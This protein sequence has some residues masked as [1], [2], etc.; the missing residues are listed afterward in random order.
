MNLKEIMKYL[1]K[2][3]A[4][5]ER[6]TYYVRSVLIPRYETDVKLLEK[7]RTDYMSVDDLFQREQVGETISVEEF[8]KVVPEEFR[9]ESL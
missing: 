4:E 6:S 8:N 5:V 9:R 1:E 3:V 2:Q 7:L